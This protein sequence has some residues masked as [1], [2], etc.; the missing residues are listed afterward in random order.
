MQT[1]QYSQQSQI[2]RTRSEDRVN[3]MGKQSGL[4]TRR[5]QGRRSSVEYHI[6]A[7]TWKK[8]GKNR[9]KSTRGKEA[10]IIS[11]RNGFERGVQRK[12]AK[13]RSATAKSQPS[14]QLA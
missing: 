9:R 13:Q 6:K 11:Y 1:V 4:Q 5:V 3:D 14:L 2:R 8:T 10:G 7:S 12:C